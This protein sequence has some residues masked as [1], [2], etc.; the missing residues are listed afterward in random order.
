MQRQGQVGDDVG[1]PV[2]EVALPARPHQRVPQAHQEAVAGVL[3]LGHV[4]A[5]AI[6][7]AHETSVAPVGEFV[8]NTLIAPA[9]LD[10]FDDVQRGR[11]LDQ[12]LGIAGSQVQVNDVRQALLFRVDGEVDLSE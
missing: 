7:E 11:E 12:P 3:G 9:H 1:A 6:V 10:R 5:G 4:R 8:E 2:N